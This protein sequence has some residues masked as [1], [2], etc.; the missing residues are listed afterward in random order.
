MILAPKF[1]EFIALSIHAFIHNN[2]L[3]HC[4]Y[5]MIVCFALGN[6][7]SEPLFED[8]QE[9]VFEESDV[10]LVGYKASILDQL[11]TYYLSVYSVACRNCMIGVSLHEPMLETTRILID[12][13]LVT[14]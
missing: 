6:S 10:F 2:Y 11:C 9:Q 5:L 1:S 7:V 3:L 13:F 14:P 8:F 4:N 12:Y